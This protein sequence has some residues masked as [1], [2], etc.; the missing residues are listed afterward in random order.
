[1][2]FFAILTTGYTSYMTETIYDIKQ[3]IDQCLYWY[4]ITEIIDQ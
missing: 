3:L 4:M 2:D 1:M